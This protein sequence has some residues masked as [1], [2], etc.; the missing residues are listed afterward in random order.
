[1]SI[2]FILLTMLRSIVI[3]LGEIKNYKTAL[4]GD[5]TENA[6]E[7]LNQIHAIL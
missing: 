7:V 6:F 3:K 2:V 5:L 1:M 4:T